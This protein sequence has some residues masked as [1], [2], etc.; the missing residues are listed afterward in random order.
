M[1]PLY[2]FVLTI[3]LYKLVR[4]AI[5]SLAC[6]IQSLINV[7]SWYNHLQ[8]YTL[9]PI[10]SHGADG[11]IIPRRTDGY[12]S[13]SNRAKQQIHRR[14]DCFLARPRTELYCTAY[15]ARHTVERVA[16]NSAQYGRAVT[17]SN[18]QT[19]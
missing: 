13:A 12:H 15:R 17:A 4:L 3:P 14:S 8:H 6:G 1:S 11:L 16:S 5:E 19:H 9:P 18:S 2:H 7:Q 10:H